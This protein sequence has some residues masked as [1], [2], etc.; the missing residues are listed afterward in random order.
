MKITYVLP[1]PNFASAK[2]K[3]GQ[4]SHALGVI[5]GIER[6]NI[7]IQVLGEKNIS[8]FYGGRNIRYIEGISGGY[9]INTIIYA[10]KCLAISSSN[11]SD[12][13]LIRKSVGTLLLGILTLNF[14]LIKSPKNV[15]WE[16]NGYTFENYNTNIFGAALYN[17]SVLAHKI[18]LRKSQGIYVVSDALKEKISSGFFSINPEKI[19]VIP[20]G[21]PNWKG[22][23]KEE[24]KATKFI[25]FGVFQSYNDFSCVIEAFKLLKDK[26]TNVEL[27]FCG[28]GKEEDF[29]E[30]ES[31]MDEDIYFWGSKVFDNL[32]NEGIATKK[33]IGLIP[34]KEI[35]TSKILSPIKMFEY[36]ALGMPIVVSNA[37]KLSNDVDMKGLI[38]TYQA[39][40]NI[41]LA[42]V[43]EE[44]LENNSIWENIESKSKNLVKENNWASRMK[45]LIKF[46]NI[47]SVIN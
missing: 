35:G 29:I 39:G 14:R 5:D 6:N 27:H 11:D 24:K 37:A 34:L 10:Y 13:V 19:I 28:Y 3:G 8:R 38:F 46:I 43:M 17:L 9:L 25:F 31:R 32:Y 16:V 18:L 23:I 12:A 7:D 40:N 45:E 20:N 36:I 41:D 44:V 4:V 22:F 1:D 2:G 26:Y 33:S 15:F 21:G 42:R 30:E 47:K